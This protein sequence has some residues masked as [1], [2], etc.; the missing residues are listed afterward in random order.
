MKI[1]SYSV[2]NVGVCKPLI[3]FSWSSW[4]SPDVM[5][6]NICCISGL[7]G[8]HS[9]HERVGFIYKI[10]LSHILLASSALHTFNIFSF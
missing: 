4:Y 8:N 3:N 10:Q 9:T 6:S 1:I 7:D 2:G 5:S